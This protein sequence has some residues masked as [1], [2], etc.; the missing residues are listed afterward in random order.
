MPMTRAREG[1]QDGHAAQ[2]VQAAQVAPGFQAGG[3]AQASDRVQARTLAERHRDACGV[4]FVARSDGR[5]DRGVIDTAL[6]ALERLVH[7]GGLAA[8]GQTGDGAGLLTAVPR[9]FLAR[10][11]VRSGM[12]DPGAAPLGV[13]VCFLPRDPDAARTAVH[14]IEEACL[15]HGVRL[16]GWRSVPV[17]PG[18]LG[19][20]ARASRPE[21]R[22]GLLV[23]EGAAETEEFE[24]RL[25]LARRQVERAR[26]PGLYVVSMSCRV[27]VYKG[28]M[29]ADRIADFYPDLR[30]PLFHSPF[31]V[32]H[33]RY[34]TNTTPSW[35]RAQ[36]FRV[37]AHNGEINTLQGNVNGMRAREPMLEVPDWPEAMTHRHL[38]RDI[39]DLD[40]SD[41][42]MLDNVVELLLRAGR[43]LPH[44]MAMLVPEVWEHIPDLPDEVRH[45]Y[46]FHACL[47]EPWDGPAALVFADGRWVGARLDRNGLRPM[48]YAVLDDGTVLAGSEVG[49]FDVDPARIRRLGKLGP[50]QMIAV[51]LVNRRFQDAEEL[52]RRLAARRPYGEWLA[53]RLARLETGGAQ[54]RGTPAGE[55]RAA[56]VLNGRVSGGTG[57]WPAAGQAVQG[58]D[59]D[60]A[61]SAFGYTREELT[62]VLRPMAEIGKEP[63]GSMGDDTPH[64]V[65]SALPRPLFHYF[66]QRFAQVTNPAIDHLRERLVF[67]LTSRIGPR[68]NLLV[69]DPEQARMLELTSPFLSEEDLD[70]LVEEAARHGMSAAVLDA[71]FPV[72]EGPRGLSAAVER[73]EADAARAVEDGATLLILSD[74]ATGPDRAPVPALLAVGAVHHHLLRLGARARVSLVSDSGEPREVHHMA[75]LVGYGASAICPYLAL[76]AVR[77]MAGRAGGRAAAGEGAGAGAGAAGGG[78]TPDK[79]QR[80]FIKACEEGLLKVMSKMGVSTFDAYH[81]AQIFEAV[82]LS[83]DLIERCFAGTPSRVGGIGLDDLAADVLAWHEAACGPAGRLLASYGFYKFRKDGEH[84]AFSPAVVRAIHDSVQHAG[85]PSEASRGGQAGET[86]GSTRH[87]GLLEGYDRFRRFLQI[88][89]EEPP[90]QLRDLFELV[91]DRDPVP[92]D[93]VEPIEEIVRR[94][95]TAAISLG[96]I[97][98]EAHETL[99]V[100]MNRLG[101]RSNSGEGGEDPARYGSEKSSAVKQVASGRFG[102]TPAY[103][104]SA[105]EI[106]IKIAQGSKP[107]EGG[108]IP[109][110][111]VTALIARL[112]HTVPGVELISPPPHHDIYSIEDLAQLIYDLKQANPQALISVKLVAETGV[113]IIAAGVAKGGADI[114]HIAGHA[115]GTGSSPLSSIK[116]AGLPWE[117]GLAET[118]RELIANDLRRGVAVRIDGGLRTGRDVVIAALLGADE[119]SFGTAALVAEGCVMARA[120]HANTCPVGIATQEPR[121]RSRFPGT[122]QRVMAYFVMV[123]QH[124]RELLA[125]LGY[126]SLDEIIGRVDLLRQRRTGR[127]AVDRLDLSA[128]LVAPGDPQAPRRRLLARNP[129]P[130]DRGLGGRLAREL[131]GAV[132]EARPVTGTYAITNRDRSVGAELAWEIARRYGDDGLP[133]GT[134]RLRFEGWAGQSFGA[135]CINGMDL[136]LVGAA[137]DY[138]GKG[139]SGGSI[140]VRPFEGM[141]PEGMGPEGVD[142]VGPAAR[143][144]VGA[145]AGSAAGLADPLAAPPVLVGNTV[146]YGATGGRLYVAGAAG[147]RF[148]VRN[149]GAVAVVEG[150]GDHGCEYM[151]GGIVVVLGRVGHNFGAGMTGG[152]AFI[153]DPSGLL[154]HR[155][156]GSF[157]RIVPVAPGSDAEQALRA[158]IQAHVDA[159]GSP[160]ARRLLEAWHQELARFRHVVPLKQPPQVLAESPG[161]NVDEARSEVAAARAR[162]VPS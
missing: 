82:G 46:R 130:M 65:M 45:F 50:G 32:F 18:A 25:F 131:A 83:Q 35:E 58:E 2:A 74:R 105:V 161:A 88:T 97:S 24:R 75:A 127:P 160:R 79:A 123:A 162:T 7:R 66:R 16:L 27:V 102:V 54:V 128:L 68:P 151:T 43:H 63:N 91:P 121:L 52:R 101:G 112:R 118:Q 62:V 152:Q 69:E 111:K 72:A 125:A 11:A 134:V 13:A 138:V 147:E 70:A 117:L 71:T 81:G 137:N 90:S 107:G 19:P 33:Q 86:N 116:N 4:G 44:V 113:G 31:A 149:S 98:P 100:A 145:A 42:A 23:P 9:D 26:V 48:R 154:E 36:P 56:P 29:T 93:E 12:R 139:M 21:V 122:P 114:V 55:R 87:A 133:P 77:A 5:S 150:I 39:I 99:A 110:H 153:Y 51:D 142:P 49:I 85:G 64:A 108:Q 135:F 6:T 103:L 155:V 143:A 60:R 40:G 104:A 140:A 106:Q 22:Q 146:L 92:L 126:R 89:G 80:N 148:A 67:S 119:Y 120:C 37:L 159:T 10:E 30:D 129:L 34:S 96:S 14:T 136:E 15:Q 8:D 3:A 53:G 109:G 156:N 94:F 28:L 124:V 144:G 76:R 17:D 84:H 132:A 158:L 95:S 57:L 1:V 61:M 20:V 41:S 59:L 115:G 73:L 157:V 47:T 78:L 141:G 38:L